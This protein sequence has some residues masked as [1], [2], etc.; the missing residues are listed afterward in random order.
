MTEDAN[1][2]AEEVEPEVIEAEAEIVEEDTSE[3]SESSTEKKDESPKVQERIDELTRYRRE[4][5]R[6]RDHWRELAMKGEPEKQTPVEEP[7]SL[8]VK[9]LEDFDYDE[10][11]YQTY[12]FDTAQTQAVEA[13]KRALEEDRTAHEAQVRQRE[14]QSKEKAYAETVED[15]MRVTRDNSLS[16]TKEM[17]DIA[18]T[19]DEGPALL[20][21]LGKNPDI[22]DSLSRLSPLAAAR[23]MGKIESKLVKESQ[24]SKAPPP[25]PKIEGVNPGHKVKPNTPASDKLS[26]EDWLKAR[27][28]QLAK[29]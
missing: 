8:E 20:Y 27:N 12:I 10:K 11:A 18:T 24:P 4:A 3:P 15:Y 6:D 16:L 17:V 22:A 21:Y 14:F 26:T 9:T 5:E 19:S 2:P 13:A 7:V 23:E 28:K 25:T 29:G 1:T